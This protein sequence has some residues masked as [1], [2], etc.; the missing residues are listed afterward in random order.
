MGQQS[1]AFASTQTPTLTSLHQ[2]KDPAQCCSICN[3]TLGLPRADG[4]IESAAILPCSHVFGSICIM[5]WLETEALN[6]DCPNCRRKMVYWGCGHLI[7]PCDIAW[8]PRCVG[9]KDMPEKCLMCRGSGK[10]GAELKLRNERRMLE[11]SALEVLRTHLPSV[12][13]GMCRSRVES[14]DS[15]IE[16]LRQE[17][18]SDVD[19]LCSSFEEQGRD[20]W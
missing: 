17:W 14:V 1:T 4:K 5:R 16:E 9:E 3:E 6:H 15:R 8:A 18:R 19:A 12:F 20:Q 7:R 13:G 10:L 11:E 2:L